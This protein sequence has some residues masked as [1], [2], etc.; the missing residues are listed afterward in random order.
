M[1]NVHQLSHFDVQMTPKLTR[2]LGIAL[3]RLRK[4]KTR[5]WNEFEDSP[6]NINL[7]YALDSQ[8]AFES[9]ELELKLKYERKLAKI[10]KH[11][12]KALFAYVRSKRT[13]NNIVGLPKKHDSYSKTK[14]AKEYAELLADYFSSVFINEPFGP[15]REECYATIPGTSYIGEMQIDDNEMYRLMNG[16]DIYKS[17]GPD[18]IHS[19][20]LKVLSNNRM[21]VRA[22]GCLFRSCSQ[23]ATMPKKGCKSDPSNYRP[24]SFT[25]ILCK[26]YEKRLRE[27]ILQHVK[28]EFSPFQHGFTS[29]KSCLFNLLKTVEQILYYL[30][31]GNEVDLIYPDFCKAFDSVPHSRLLIK[32]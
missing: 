10:V 29:G 7:Q 2:Y 19:R 18:E 13:T 17:Q 22:V 14:S 3:K 20:L 1:T 28:R 21:F 4:Q 31:N 16:L 5:K 11:N 32:L 23:H 24:I 6:T 27:H 12:P 30:D 15:M 26:I 9:A 25:Y 8:K